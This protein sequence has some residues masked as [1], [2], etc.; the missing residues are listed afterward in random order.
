[1]LL[2]PS[3]ACPR[4]RWAIVTVGAAFAFTTTSTLTGHEPGPPGRQC[5]YAVVPPTKATCPATTARSRQFWPRSPS[6]L[7]AQ[8]RTYGSG[9]SASAGSATTRATSS[10]MPMRMPPML[11]QSELRA[12]RVGVDPLQ[13][14]H[15]VDVV[16]R[17]GELD[18]PPFL[19]PAVDV[20]L[21]GVVRG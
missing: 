18:P 15:A 13:L 20:G 21:A 10:A 12:V 11:G 14:L 16:A 2:Y 4:E 5:W 3:A 1:M 19:A 6:W 7:V 17:L 9:S 8:V